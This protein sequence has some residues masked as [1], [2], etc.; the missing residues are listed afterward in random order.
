MGQVGL[1]SPFMFGQAQQRASTAP[2]K[3]IDMHDMPTD[4]LG[5]ARPQTGSAGA[6]GTD[7]IAV[8]DRAET[9]RLNALLLAVARDAN[10]QAYV[11]LFHHFAPRLKSYL[12]RMGADSGQAE[13]I[14]QDVMVSV[15]RK[16]AS[17]DPAVAT[18]ATWV[19]A[20]ARNRRI[21]RLRRERRPEI[22]P[23]DPALVPDGEDPADQTLQAEQESERLHR[24]IR[25]LPPE[26]AELLMMAYFEDKPHSQIATERNLPLGTVKSRLRLALGR[27]RK[28]LGEEE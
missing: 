6:A 21:D 26:Q 25:S 1:Y 14:I 13:E 19:F 9:E 12:R 15:W 16:A 24:A 28:A 3:R 2:L 17:F 11:Q 10:R 5:A 8:A 20:I 22:D 4:T 27:L 7:R 23:D 18:A